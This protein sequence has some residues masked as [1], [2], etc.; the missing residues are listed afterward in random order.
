M[1]YPHC[2]AC[3]RA[4]IAEDQRDGLCSQFS[5][6]TAKLAPVQYQHFG[7]YNAF[8][9]W[10]RTKPYYDVKQLSHDPHIGGSFDFSA[11]ET[12]IAFD[13]WME[14]GAPVV[15]VSNEEFVF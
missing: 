10:L 7:C 15:P 13:E 9:Q 11:P 4:L 6:R 1:N 12:Q 14:L 8:H 5:W 2:R 3:G